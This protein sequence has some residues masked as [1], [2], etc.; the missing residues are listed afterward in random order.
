MIKRS[1]WI[2]L[3]LFAA[4][5]GSSPPVDYYALQTISGSGTAAP[6]DA[7]IIGLGPLEVPGYLDRPQLVTQSSD[8]KVIVDEFN[9]WAEP[10]ANALPRIVTANVD[11]L[12]ESAVVVSFPYGARIRADY[13]LAGRIL[14]FD[15][16]RSGT[17][18]LEVQWGV[19][20][21]KANNLISPR[22]SR[23]TAVAS[24]SQDPG[25]VVAALNQTVAAFSRDIASELTRLLESE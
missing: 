15:A 6:A 14:R 21:A 17:A 13:H 11:E 2:A 3:L 5:C 23:Y 22:R 10:L 16:D 20:D 18:V 7:R 19:Q 9:R 1:P 24:P 25:A 4:S 8:G 12:L